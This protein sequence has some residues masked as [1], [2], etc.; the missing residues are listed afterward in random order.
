MIQQ[1]DIVVDEVELSSGWRKT[2]ARVVIKRKDGK[3]AILFLSVCNVKQ[4]I[5][6]KVTALKI[7]GKET[8][9]TVTAN[10]LAY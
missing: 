2:V 5:K 9:K 1:Q 8:Q 3:R 7:G 4:G 6:G 10:W